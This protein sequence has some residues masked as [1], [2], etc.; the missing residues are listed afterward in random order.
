M[1]RRLSKR[2]AY[3]CF[4]LG[5]GSRHGALRVSVVMLCA[6]A[7]A[8]AAP[9]SESRSETGRGWSEAAPPGEVRSYQLP[10]WETPAP[11]PALRRTELAHHLAAE[12]AGTDLRRKAA[13]DERRGKPLMKIH[14]RQQRASRLPRWPTSPEWQYDASMFGASLLLFLMSGVIGICR[15]LPEEP[16]D[17]GQATLGLLPA[18]PLLF[19]SQLLRKRP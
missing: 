16:P 12:L 5:G 14:R 10:Q 8:T 7:A 1:D 15:R 18:P 9:L 19:F 2:R 11:A 4:G 17:A 13:E 6:A 3:G